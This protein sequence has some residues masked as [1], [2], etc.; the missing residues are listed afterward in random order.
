MPEATAILL[1]EQYRAALLAGERQEALR[2]I[3]AYGALYQ[4]LQTQIDALT[5][6]LDGLAARNELSVWRAGRLE[7]LKRLRRQVL[8][9]LGRFAVLVE[10]SVDQGARAAVQVAMKNGYH[11]VQAAL[12]GIPEADAA[13][14]A[15][16]QTLDPEAVYS[17]LGLFS[18]GSP[19]REGLRERFGEEIAAR[20][21]A[22]LVES[23]G[24]GYNPRKLAAVFR[25]QLGMGLVSALRTA[26]TTQLYAYR[27]ATR[28]AYMANKDIVPQW[29]WRAAK[30]SR[31][32]MSCIAMD[33]T[34]HPVTERLNDHHNGRCAMVPVPVSY[35][36]LGLDVAESPAPDEWL[37]SQPEATQRRLLGARYDEW[38]AGNLR[39]GETARQW[40]ERQPEAVQRAMMG[41]GKHDAWKAGEFRLE[42]LSMVQDD[43]VWGRMRVET[44]LKALVGEREVAAA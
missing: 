2:L 40:F 30:D 8:D 16:W 42:Q 6:D 19:L 15:V 12:P 27:E 36:A 20:A 24:L 37:R 34:L 7:S 21:E 9:E 4:R 29:R 44:P 26:R 38:R 3:S 33:G 31:T 10:D 28:A 41:P 39:F 14:M 13:I 5:A 23:I 11:L 1:A 22:R 35:R 18:E 17:A 43:P 32:C 25:D